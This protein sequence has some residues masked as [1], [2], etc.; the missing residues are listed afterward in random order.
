M[1]FLDGVDPTQFLPYGGNGLIALVIALV[2]A[3]ITGVVSAI[4]WAEWRR[5]KASIQAESDRDERRTLQEERRDA[6]LIAMMD[7]YTSSVERV[8]GELT[9][10]YSKLVDIDARQGEHEVADDARWEEFER[11]RKTLGTH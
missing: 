5:G 10:V 4:L 7:R 3:T 2:L 1:V 8:H 9:K 11:W 6:A